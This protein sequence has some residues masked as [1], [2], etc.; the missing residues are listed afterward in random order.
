LFQPFTLPPAWR[1]FNQAFLRAAVP[2]LALD[3]ILLVAFAGA[4]LL[5]AA[6]V[7][8][9]VP[10]LLGI[11]REQ[12]IPETLNYAKWAASLVFLTA[13]FLRLRRPLFGCLAMLFLMILADDAL[14]I[15]ERLGA[16]LAQG[17]SI[18]PMQALDAKH[19]GEIVVFGGMGFVALALLGAAYL[20]AGPALRPLVNRFLLVIAGLAVTGVAFDA[21]HHM[22]SALQPSPLRQAAG[23]ILT[24]V[25]D[26]GEMVF[27]SLAAAY[28]WAAWSAGRHGRVDG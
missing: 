10:H 5:A 24:I 12:S 6:E 1:H 2:L 15:H 21:A 8:D 18:P 13:C 17:L 27:A 14:L 22:S 25:E 11:S 23:L 16:D 20:G 3:G 28:A 9:Y 7:L 4:A 26:G 19:V